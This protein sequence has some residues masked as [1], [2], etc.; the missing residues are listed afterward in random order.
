MILK[1][2]SILLDLVRNHQ[3][4]LD[5]RDISGNGKSPKKLPNKYIQ[6]FENTFNKVEEHEDVDE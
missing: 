4:I 1:Q 6:A 5:M 2:R 3:V